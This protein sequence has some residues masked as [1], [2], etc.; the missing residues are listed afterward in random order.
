M[1]FPSHLRV[2]SQNFQGKVILDD[3]K[4]ALA[5]VQEFDAKDLEQSGRLGEVRF[6]AAIEP[7]QRL[8][9]LFRQLPV[10]ALDTLPSNELT[11]VKS[12]ANS[13]YQLFE[14]I[15]SFDV[16]EGDVRN[17]QTQA[18]DKVNAAYQGVFSKLFPLISYSMARTVDFNQLE[19]QGRATVQTIKDQTDALMAEL[20]EQ[21]NQASAILDEVRQAAAEQGVSQQAVYFRD[22]A[23]SHKSEAVLWRK[24]TIGVAIAVGLYGVTTLFLH[25]VPFL[26]PENTYE[27]VQFT[28]GKLLVFFVLTYMLALCSKNFLSNRHNEI[29]NRHRQN[30]LMTYKA[31]VDAGGTPEARDVILNHAA[32]SI[33]RLHETD[34]TKPSDGSG[35]SSSSIIEM[36]PRTSLPLN[37][38]SP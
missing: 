34:Y 16:N 23:D 28:V 17:R 7:A 22:E 19:T 14:Q 25:K 29:V 27:T 11:Q 38:P 1:I 37:T 13:I 36:L 2:C 3:A 30:A 8:I 9:M 35:S 32:A 24:R 15:L 10:A 33:Y 31:L 4:A 18:I 20:E 5:R 26:S 21:K 6:H 12:Q